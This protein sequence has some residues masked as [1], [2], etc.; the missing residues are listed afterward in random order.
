MKRYK[1]ERSEFLSRMRKEK[2][3]T[4]TNLSGCC[5]DRFREACSEKGKQVAICNK[6]QG[7]KKS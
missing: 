2:K 7:K 3:R 5:G 6:E 4:G 1:E